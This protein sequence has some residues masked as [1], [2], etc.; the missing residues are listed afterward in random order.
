M[1]IDGESVRGPMSFARRCSP[2]VIGGYFG[3]FPRDVHVGRHV[4]TVS[5]STS[6]KKAIE[7]RRN[8]PVVVA[9]GGTTRCSVDFHRSFVH[10]ASRSPR[11]TTSVPG[12][13]ATSCHSPSGPI[14]CS[15]GTPSAN[16]NVHA[17]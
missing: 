12:S 1:A 10:C 8:G 7:R 11:L 6:W 5:W 2:A 3:G 4:T 14:I 13:A 9:G 16:S 15:P 17:P